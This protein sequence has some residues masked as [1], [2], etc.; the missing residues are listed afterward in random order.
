MSE[1]LTVH[2]EVFQLLNKF[3]EDGRLYFLYGN[4]DMVKSQKP[5]VQYCYKHC[6]DEQRK[7]HTPLFNNIT[8]HEGLILRYTVTGR[9]ILLI[10]GHQ[11]SCLDYTFWGLRRF[12]VRHV[13]KRLELLGFQDPT[14]TAKNYHKQDTIEQNLTAWVKQTN[15]MLIAGHTHRPMYPEPDKP[16]YFNDGSCVHPHS[17][18]GIEITGGNIILVKWDV[19]IREDGSL[20]IGR[21]ILEGPRKL[22]EYG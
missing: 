14:S 9:K 6:Y 4:H 21:E 1:I 11:G 5:D 19:K 13:W 7:Q 12:L 22:T 15:H 20:Y 17:I 18:T 10:H 2:K 16:H 8:F 3:Y